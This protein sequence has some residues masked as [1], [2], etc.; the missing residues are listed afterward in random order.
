MKRFLLAI[1]FVTSIFN[2]QILI[3]QTNF[4]ADGIGRS[5]DIR[6]IDFTDLSRETLPSQEKT[7]AFDFS[8]FV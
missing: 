5:F 1:A 8:N 4:N 3:A 6:R 2:S 7:Y